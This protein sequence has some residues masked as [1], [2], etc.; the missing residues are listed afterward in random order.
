M[1]DFI[2]YLKDKYGY[3]DYEIKLLEYYIKSLLYDLCKLI[4]IGIFFFAFGYFTEYLIAV[5]TLFLIRSSLGGL[6]FKRYFSCLVFT[7]AFFITGI[8]MLPTI[9]L[10]TA[11]ML[12]FLLICMIITNFIGPIVSC[13]RETPSGLLIRKCKKKSTIIIFI[14][15]LLIFITPDNH[16]LTIGFWVII[17]QTLQLVFAYI[18]HREGVKL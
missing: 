11:L 10:N 9:Y 7:T 3:S 14:Y 15:C 4:P 18:K 2:T 17:L 6:H 12:L 5:L 1:K 8:L 13:Y 16:Y